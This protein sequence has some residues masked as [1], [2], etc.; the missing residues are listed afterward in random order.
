MYYVTLKNK[1]G[2]NA[3]FYLAMEE[4]IARNF[5]RLIDADENGVREAFFIWS[6]APTALLGRNQFIEAEINRAYCQEHNVKC[7]RRKSGGGCIYM[8]EGNIILGYVSSRTDAQA[9]FEFYLDKVSSILRNLGL[10]ARF[11]GRNDI[12]IA[13]KKIS[14]NAF[15]MLPNASIVHGTLLYDSDFEAMTKVL[16]PSAAKIKSKGVASIRQRVTNIRE[17]L[18]KLPELDKKYLERDQFMNYLITSFCADENGKVWEKYLG[19]DDLQEIYK[20]E[21]A[22]ADKDFIEGKKQDYSLEYFG[23]IDNV[24]ELHIFFDMKD[25]LIYSCHVE[26]DYFPIKTDLD[27]QLTNLLRNKENTEDSIREALHDI[28]LEE[29][30]MNIN[31]EQFIKLI[32]K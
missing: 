3:I 27:E 1:E 30:I 22:Y 9:T 5:E 8:D 7:F 11:T 13:E 32:Y 16:T 31:K 2:R 26:G 24:G 14:G 4:Y 15:Y 17:E 19:D 12:Q 10:D 18:E 29:Y 21:A 23:K 6:V 28:R 25:G 20:I